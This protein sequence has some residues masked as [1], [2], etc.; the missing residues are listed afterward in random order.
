ME[1]LLVLTQ[2]PLQV[3]SETVAAHR[4]EDGPSFPVGLFSSPRLLGSSDFLPGLPETP[5]PSY[6]KFCICHRQPPCVEENCTGLFGGFESL[7]G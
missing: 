4:L 7:Q 5:R 2:I 1:L 6:P 3:V